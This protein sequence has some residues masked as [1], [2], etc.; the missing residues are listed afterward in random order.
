MDPWNT[1]TKHLVP[2]QLAANWA[3]FTISAAR[4]IR[5]AAI[6]ASAAATQDLSSNKKQ[7][8]WISVLNR[9]RDVRCVSRNKVTCWCVPEITS[10]RVTAAVCRAVCDVCA[11]C[12]V[13]FEQG[14]GLCS[15]SF[16]E[17]VVG[18]EP[19]TSSGCAVVVV[20]MS[21]WPRKPRATAGHVTI[22]APPPVHPCV[23][24]SSPNGGSP[25]CLACPGLVGKLSVSCAPPR[26]P[27]I[28]F[29]LWA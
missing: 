23:Y 26:P 3:S 4:L 28:L 22:R 18:N 6:A 1:S 10:E 7:L 20:T 24:E 19:W 8:L 17:T 14:N 15:N 27:S 2:R 9:L 13:D 25:F 5:D 11:L 21:L 16:V 29:I 12:S